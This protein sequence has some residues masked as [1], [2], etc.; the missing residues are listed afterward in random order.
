MEYPCKHTGCPETFKHRSLPSRHK[1][2][3]QFPP[4]NKPFEKVDGGYQCTSCQ[5]KISHANNLPR[6]K[7]HCLQPPKPTFECS[8]CEKRFKFE[9]KLNEHVK[10]H[11]RR[12]FEDHFQK[13]RSKPAN[14]T[15][16]L[17]TLVTS[18]DV[19]N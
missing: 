11:E 8:Q 14:S 17:P 3:C 13:H 5:A 15:N 19:N 9:S 10:V 18:H 7:A 4:P 1:T 6:Y 16:D 2:I 12:E